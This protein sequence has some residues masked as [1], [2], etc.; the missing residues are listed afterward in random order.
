M[1][2]RLAWVLNITGVQG[3]HGKARPGSNWG[4]ASFFSFLLSLMFCS[5]LQQLEH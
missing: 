2:A 5:L 4:W 3:L 1:M